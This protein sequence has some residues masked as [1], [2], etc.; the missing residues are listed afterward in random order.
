M[1]QE[2][3]DAVIKKSLLKILAKDTAIIAIISPYQPFE[4]IPN[5]TPEIGSLAKDDFREAI[6]YIKKNEIDK[7]FVLV[8]SF[9]GAI[10]SLHGIIQEIRDNFD[11][12]IIFV[13]HTNI[14]GGN[15]S[16]S[17]KDRMLMGEAEEIAYRLNIG[18]TADFVTPFEEVREIINEN[19]LK[20]IEKKDLWKIMKSWIRKYIKNEGRYTIKF[21]L[22]NL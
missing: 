22:P 9:V 18:Q 1:Y 2:E 19:L 15:L 8:D 16:V 6:S 7:L 10:T 4:L 13:P 17:V 14:D 3:T 5:I 21:V 11:Y 20:C 12:F